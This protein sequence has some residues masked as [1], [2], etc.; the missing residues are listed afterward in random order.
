[1]SRDPVRV[2]SSPATHDYV[3]HLRH[4]AAGGVTW[5]RGPDVEGWAPSPALTPAWV[6]ANADA[7]DVVHLHFGF[8]DRTPAELTQWVER[9]HA[10]GIALI[11]TVHDL[12]NPHHRDPGAH[13]AQLDVLVTAADA[14]VTLTD[15]AAAEIRRRWGRDALVVPHPHVVPDGLLDAPRP[16]H[17]GYV[18]GVHLKSMRANVS[19]LAVLAPLVDVVRD[20][21]D[22]RLVVDVHDELLIP[23]FVRHDAEL[24]AFVRAAA[25][26]GDLT[27]N[28]HERFDD[29]QLWD[30]LLGVDLSVLPYAF[31]THSGWLEA[32]HDLGTAVLA[33][34]VGRWHEQ[35]PALGFDLTLDAD[36]EVRV[37]ADRLHATVRHAYATRPSWRAD[38]AERRRQRVEIALAHRDLY[39]SVVPS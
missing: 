38:P 28:A 22:A 23:D 17:D 39:R 11:Y 14:L 10:N 18:V 15:G 9:L 21:P 2:L 36:G 35:Q 5:V 7:V 34:R 1:M 20:I 13:D 27:L 12:R 29:A 8:D 25:E 30:Y 6:D 3:E 31:G 32:C 4:P 16:A 33:P 37:D 19:G 26:R 24:V